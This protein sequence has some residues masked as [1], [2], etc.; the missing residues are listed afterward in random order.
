MVNAKTVIDAKTRDYV[1]KRA[2]SA[3]TTSEIGQLIFVAGVLLVVRV[4]R[5]VPWP[6]WCRMVPVYGIGSLAAFWCIQRVAGF[7]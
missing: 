6:A 7:W 5:P 4:I 3:R 2:K 1:V